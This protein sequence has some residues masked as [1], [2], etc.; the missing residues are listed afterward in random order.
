MSAF[1]VDIRK[2]K[3]TQQGKQILSYRPQYDFLKRNKRKQGKK[4]KEMRMWTA[5]IWKEQMQQILLVH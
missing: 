5:F 4:D 3:D 1:I 2:I